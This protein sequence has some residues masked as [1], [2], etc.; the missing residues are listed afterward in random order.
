M[1]TKIKTLGLALLAT[2]A[3][4]AL[5]AQGAGAH[6]FRVSEAPADITGTGGGFAFATSAF[7]LECEASLF[8]GT[9]AEETQQTIQLTPSATN[10]G[11]GEL[12]ATVID[13][14]CS[15]VLH[16][17][18]AENP[19]TEGEDGAVDFDCSHLGRIGLRIY[20]NEAHEVPICEITVADTH[21]GETEVN[22]GLHGVHYEN[23]EGEQEAVNASVRL[24]NVAYEVHD[25][26]LCFLLGLEEG[27]H[28]D[29]F[30]E[31]STTL[32]VYAP[33][34]VHTEADQLDAT[35]E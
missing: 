35:V 30:L 4:G 1:T 8:T 22:Q 28:T 25:P 34:E 26:G 11:G 31:A 23:V 21:A 32:R 24:H 15:L 3:L 13:A 29:G 10:C 18:T 6:E 16:G 7:E 27:T 33:P 5:A 12:P 19:A 14:G 2:L 17:E 9:Q 20:T